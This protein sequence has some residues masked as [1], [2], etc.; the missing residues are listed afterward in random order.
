MIK[1]PPFDHGRSIVFARFTLSVPPEIKRIKRPERTGEFVCD[2]AIPLSACPTSNVTGTASMAG[3]GW[4]MGKLKSTVWSYMQAQFRKQ[5]VE[6]QFPLSG[7]PQ[8]MAVRFSSTEPDA[9]SNWAKIPI[10]M[11]TVAKI[12]NGKPQQHRLGI[13]QDDAPRVVDV[14]QHWEPAKVGEGFVYIEVRTGES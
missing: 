6:R 11:L 5:R 2:F 3:Q 13:I 12:R 1:R 9:C 8:I 10:D 4:R 7:R 14:S